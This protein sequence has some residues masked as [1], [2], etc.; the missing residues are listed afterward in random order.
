MPVVEITI[1]E[2][3]GRIVKEQLIRRLTD[4]VVETLD[5]EPGRV[6][7][8]IREVRDGN[9]A[10]GGRPLYLRERKGADPP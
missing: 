6:R 4:A 1:L 9:Y 3:R 7:V 8:I 10:V 2:G 5:A